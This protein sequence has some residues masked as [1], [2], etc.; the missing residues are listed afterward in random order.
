[1]VRLICAQLI[2]DR[3]GHLAT[4][5]RPHLLRVQS[6]VHLVARSTLVDPGVIDFLGRAQSSVVGLIIRLEPLL[7]IGA[8]FILEEAQLAVL[9]VVGG[10][11][12]SNP[13][14]RRVPILL[15]LLGLLPPILLFV[16]LLL[17]LRVQSNHL[18]EDRLLLRLVVFDVHERDV[19]AI[20]NIQNFALGETI[21][22]LLT[23]ECTLSHATVI[24]VISGTRI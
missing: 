10:P 23:H 17:R 13:I 1:M 11:V 14:R 9:I 18:R 5:L 16:G 19:W 6:V 3:L 7:Q 12:V 22:L 21:M 15:L 4:F 24:W 20:F 8:L 2:D